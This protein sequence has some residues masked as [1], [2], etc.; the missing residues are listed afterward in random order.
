M[1]A[2]VNVRT[3]RRDAMLFAILL[4]LVLILLILLV[5]L[6]LL[7]KLKI[8]GGGGQPTPAPSPQPSIPDTL[9][10]ADLGTALAARLAGTPADGSVDSGGVPNSVIWVDQ[11]DEVLV[12]LES[13]TVRYVDQV[14]LVSMD[15]ECDQTGR[16]SLIVPFALSG[17]A[18]G[19]A[20]LLATTEEFPRGNAL[21]AARW[22]APVREAA[23][24]ALLQ[25]ATDHATER[26]MAPLGLTLEAGQLRLSAGAPLTLA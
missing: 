5:L 21:L 1:G 9:D 14:A 24:A 10:E 15:L 22:G 3:L 7:L 25:L 12:H 17:N 8:I 6:W 20:N 19:G 16:T 4:L 23:W 2:G 26:N 18:A 13:V 11:G